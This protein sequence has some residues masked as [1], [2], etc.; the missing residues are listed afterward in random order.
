MFGRVTRKNVCSDGRPERPGGVL[1]L[2]PELLEDRRHLAD[3]EGD[4]DEDR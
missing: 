3:D 1:L 2:G 4:A